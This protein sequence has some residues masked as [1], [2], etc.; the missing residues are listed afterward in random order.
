MPDYLDK[1]AL[2][3]LLRCP[4]YVQP[5][6]LKRAFRGERY[7]VEQQE[8]CQHFSITQVPKL[9]CLGSQ[10]FKSLVKN[11]LKIKAQKD[12]D[13]DEMWGSVLEIDN[14]EVYVAAPWHLANCPLEMKGVDFRR[15][16]L[17]LNG[18]LQGPPPV[19]PEILTPRQGTLL[20]REIDLAYVIPADIETG[21]GTP[22][23]EAVVRGRHFRGRDDGLMP[24]TGHLRC[25]GFGHRGKV[26]IVPE[27]SMDGHRLHSREH[28]RRFCEELLRHATCWHNGA[29]DLGWL[30]YLYGVV[31]FGAPVHDTLNLHRHLYEECPHSLA[32]ACSLEWYT[33]SWKA[34]LANGLLAR[35]DAQLWQYCGQ[36]VWN[37]G[38]LFHILVKRYIDAYGRNPIGS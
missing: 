9:I 19:R 21:P 37:T 16:E 30:Q 2:A 15:V 7:L 26:Y 13:F 31:P 6:Q 35:N 20:L 1:A 18:K 29:F 34:G 32:V 25:V 12:I 22:G 38:K 14:Q 33:G 27:F 36:D 10:A 23:E 17:W 5:D 11:R 4:G 24:H 28:M 3:P 8:K